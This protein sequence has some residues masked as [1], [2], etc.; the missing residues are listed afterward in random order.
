[1]SLA[2]DIDAVTGVLLADGW[3]VVDDASFTIDAYEYLW[4]EDTIDCD[5]IL[6][7]N[8]E[9]QGCSTGFAFVEDGSI[10]AGPMTSILAIRRAHD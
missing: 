7:Y 2:I 3:H 8:G 5:A 4:G 10:V 1:M 6:M 9:R